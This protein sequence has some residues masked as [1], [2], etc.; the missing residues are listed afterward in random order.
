MAS[1]KKVSSLLKHKRIIIAS[2]LLIG[3]IVM[4]FLT[5]LLTYINNKPKPFKDDKNVKIVSKN[6]YFTLDVVAEKISF[7][8]DKPKIELRADLSN[9]KSTLSNVKIEYEVNN[10]WTSKGNATG[11]S[12]SF[13]NGNKINP[14][15]TTT[16]NATSTINLN[17]TYPISVLP[18]VKVKHPTIFAKISYDRKLPDSMAGE[19]G[20]VSEISYY[21]FTYSDYCTNDTTFN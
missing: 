19:G 3:L 4:I 11:S 14:T 21:R 15:T 16:Y 10:Y 7:K 5:Y 6:N 9:I 8:G 20:T 17:I 18:L 2:L 12:T 13:N 1:E